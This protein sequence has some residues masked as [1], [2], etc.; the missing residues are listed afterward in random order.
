MRVT[1]SFSSLPW[2][3]WWFHVDHDGACCV[4]ITRITSPSKHFCNYSNRFC[5]LMI[6]LFHPVP[7]QFFA[8]ASYP[9]AHGDATLTTTSIIIIIIIVVVYAASIKVS[10]TPT[11]ASAPLHPGLNRNKPNVLS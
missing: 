11:A 2:S 4:S 6:S 8:V 7:N 1:D 9:A 3:M 5:C 10:T